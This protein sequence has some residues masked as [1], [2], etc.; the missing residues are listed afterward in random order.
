[1]VAD[2]LYLQKD[3]PGV[4]RFAS[5]LLIALS[6]FAVA[7]TDAPWFAAAAI[8]PRRRARFK[9]HGPDVKLWQQFSGGKANLVG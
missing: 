2:S 4:R 9:L 3:E 6:I 1:V 7:R 8:G 5:I